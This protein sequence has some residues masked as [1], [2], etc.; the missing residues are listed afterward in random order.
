MKFHSLIFRITV[1]LAGLSGITLPESFA[2][3]MCSADEVSTALNELSCFAD[4]AYVSPDSVATA[5]SDL[6]YNEYSEDACRACFNKAR[7][8][9][10]PVVKALAR[11]DLLPAPSMRSF[12]DAIDYAEDDTCYLADDWPWD[13]SAETDSASPGRA[14]PKARANSR[15]VDVRALVEDLCPCN[16]P[17]WSHYG[18]QKEFTQCA[19]TVT[20]ILVRHGKIDDRRGK[21]LVSQLQRSNCGKESMEEKD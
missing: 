15:G 17:R 10:A 19:E 4:G 9:V 1:S 3:E 13:S 8:K 21:D 11:L 2:Q 5:I 12:K 14:R 16:S 20:D 6:C 18:G 7:R